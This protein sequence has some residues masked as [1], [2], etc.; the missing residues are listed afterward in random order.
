MASDFYRQAFI[1]NIG[2][3]SEA[4]QER[5]RNTCVAIAGL[6][7]VGGLNLVTLA[8]MGFGRFHIADL[9]TFET[10]NMNRQYGATAENLGRK[11]TDVMREV[12]LGIN[13][14]I[15][16][17]V[18]EE[19]VQEEN[20]DAFFRG[21]DVAVDG[22]DF[23]AMESRRMFFNEARKRGIHVVTSGPI[24][25]GTILLTFAPD[26][27]SFDDYFGLSK[28]MDATDK[29]IAFAIGVSPKLYARTYIDPGKVNFNQRYG[30]SVAPAICLSSGLVGIEVLKIVLGRGRVRAAPHYFQFD[31]YRQIYHRGYLWGGGRNAL[32]VLKRWILKRRFGSAPS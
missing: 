13:P 9:D 17:E 18:F 32:Q 15:H 8:R 3:I 11:K 14:D 12:A 30:P 29:G 19:G 28:G 6:G 20:V 31:A 1:R 4:E 27:M 10:V 24:G 5:L 25:F 2:L 7:G 23:F 22:I 16:L 26:G 21:V